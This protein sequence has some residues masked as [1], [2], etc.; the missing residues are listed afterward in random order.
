M[1]MIDYRAIKTQL[2][3]MTCPAHNEKP[4]VTVTSGGVKLSCC[5][6]NFKQKLTEKTKTLAGEQA[7][8]YAKEEILKAFKR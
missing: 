1:A 6:E 4:T 3:R 8:K 5:C 7:A 2:E